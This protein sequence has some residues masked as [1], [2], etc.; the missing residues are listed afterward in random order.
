MA[1]RSGWRRLRRNLW[2]LVAL[3]IIVAALGAGVVQLGLPWLVRN[4]QRV[5]QWLS[6]RLERPVTIGQVSSRWLRG[7]PELSLQDVVIGAKAESGTS[8]HLDRAALAL[9][10]F[11][12]FQRN[13]AWNEFRLSGLKLD[14]V[15]QIDG[16][17]SVRGLDLPASPANQGDGLGALGALVLDNLQVRLDDPQHSL[18]LDLAAS[19]LRLVNRSAGPRILGTLRRVGSD[20]PPLNIVIDT[21]PDHRSGKAW[22]GGKAL[23][24]AT[25]T[26][27][28]P[29]DDIRIEKARGA[30]DA[31]ATWNE[32]AL[33]EMSVRFDLTDVRMQRTD[34][35]ALPAVDLD[36]LAGVARFRLD[37]DGWD[38]DVADWRLARPGQALSEPA[39][40][41]MRRNGEPARWLAGADR[42][43]IAGLAPLAT[44]AP[45]VPDGLRTWLANAAPQ[46]M[47]DHPRLRWDSATSYGI[48]TEFSGLAATAVGHIPGVASLS[49]N[50][51]GD[52]E[53]S[54]I[55]IPKQPLQ[56]DFPGIFRTPFRYSEIGGDVVAWRDDDGWH[57]KTGELT[58]EGEGYGGSLSGGVSF[59][60][61][62][63][64]PSLDV[65]LALQH[66]D[67]GAAKL[68]WPVNVMPTKAVQW[69]DDAFRSGSLTTNAVFRGNLEDFP[70][71]NDEG[72]FEAIAELD[73]MQLS[74]HPDWPTADHVNATATFVNR[75]VDVDVHSGETMRSRLLSGRASIEE[76]GKVVVEV[77]A[78]AQGRG[79]DLLAYLRATPIGRDNAAGLDGLTIGGRGDIDLKLH[80]PVGHADQITVAGDVQMH[81]APLASSKWDVKLEDGNGLLHYDQR[82]VEAKEFSVSHDGNPGTLSLAIG[83]PVAND[84]NTLELALDIP[85]TV[86]RLLQ[87][88]P[89]VAFLGDTIKGRSDWD[90]AVSIPKSDSHQSPQLKLSSNLVGTTVDLPAPI[91][92]D[93]ATARS[94]SIVLPLPAEGQEY[95][96]DYDGVLTHIGRVPRA[97]QVFAGRLD[98]GSKVAGPMPDSGIVVGGRAAELDATGWVAFAVGLSGAGSGAGLRSV[99]VH[100]DALVIGENRV[101]DVDVTMG[102]GASGTHVELAGAS[103]RG[104]IEIPSDLVRAGVTVHLPILHWPASPENS[105]PDDDARETR[106]PFAPSTAPPMHVWVGDLRVGNAEFGETRIETRPTVAGM[107]IDTLDARSPMFHLSA[108]GDWNGGQANSQTRLN[109]EFTAPD[110][111]RVLNAFGFKG[112]IDGGATEAQLSGSWPGA[113][114]AFALSRLSGTLKIDVGQGRFLEVEPGAGG[115][116]FGLLSLGEIRRRLS[117]DFTDFYKSGTTFNSIKGQ[118]EL[119]GASARTNDLLIDSPAAQV[120]ITGRT[121]LKARDY[122]QEMT[123]TPKAGVALPVVGALAGGPVGA[124][125][126]LVV[127]NLFRKQIG[128]AT[129]SRYKVSGSWDKPEIDLI[130]REP[131]AEKADA[132][133]KPAD[134][135][136]RPKP[137]Q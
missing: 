8:L 50:I 98:L 103:V 57:V 129:H 32:G 99:D 90:I 135:P 102:L 36:A 79:A 1:A 30:V 10:L 128:A 12:P 96:L 49:G 35:D 42:I 59:P 86:Q 45:G 23:D 52:A 53:A 29:L 5:E 95:R 77:Q 56:L 101:P 122:D 9:N 70:F 121:G 65:A 47:L 108:T 113:P 137:K 27:D 54:L 112:L 71:R 41:A 114:V 37:A 48:S 120:L 67:I 43:D 81:D 7:G 73:D 20:N 84:A 34:V 25:L 55:S 2:N 19:E 14:L 17:W 24:L 62:R 18:Q 111:G 97:D 31:W 83:A 85:M 127:Q 125:A 28:L 100:A 93:A 119:D 116:L 110:L 74:F 104:S 134:T 89:N 69:L 68:F 38:I 131:I 132:N 21:S 124:A 11:A 44:L 118:F 33:H 40:F 64:K 91:G 133:E 3:L 22:L 6:V 130:A 26:H 16:T 80:I 15:H 115:R 76:L 94:L 60:I 92:K 123:V 51:V 105:T 88:V 136:S 58:F 13:G 78:K 72:R 87:R 109:L 75:G 117:L 46:G 63:S 106:S 107:R 126:G 82:G 66:A 61:D 4:P 39:R